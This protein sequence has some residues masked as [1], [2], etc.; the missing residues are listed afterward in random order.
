MSSSARPE[1]RSR[2]RRLF[3]AMVVLAILG[4]ALWMRIAFVRSVDIPNLGD[5]L[6]YQARGLHFASHGDFRGS[7]Y[8]APGY[9]AFVGLHYFFFGFRDG[10]I[11]LTQAL[12]ST[13]LVLVLYLAA[14]RAFGRGA[15]LAAALLATFFP[16]FAGYAGVLF[17]EVLYLTLVAGTVW[18]A[19]EA[20]A[21][22]G[23][24]TGIRSRPLATESGAPAWVWAAGAGLLLGLATLTR[25][26]ALPLVLLFPAWFLL[27]LPG[28]PGAT[29]DR[30]AES[31]PWR[32]RVAAFPW[33]LRLGLSLAT[34]AA[35]LLVLVPWTAR[36]YV[37][38]HRVVPV[39][40]VSGLNLLIGNNPRANGTFTYIDY[41]DAYQRAVW[42]PNEAARDAVMMRE[43]LGYIRSHPGR[44]WE[45]TRL[46][47][48]YFWAQDQD[49]VESLYH[50]NRIPL[51]GTRGRVSA[52]QTAELALGLSGLALAW[53]HRHALLFAGGALYVAVAQSVFYEAP[54]YRLAAVPFL[55]LLGAYALSPRPRWWAL[56][57]LPLAALFAWWLISTRAALGL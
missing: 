33:R 30:A 51:V 9:V 49:Y 22:V 48:R 53:R 46:R 54:R 25:S 50:W 56:A 6:D 35:F 32:S 14:R 5:P 23:S 43:A 38:F 10:P 17:A 52:I 39:D 27:P 45:L 2:R 11:Y 16:P 40:T 26:I 21:R 28:S 19:V 31:F 47:W 12:L 55:I 7:S 44:F 4:V 13:L 15:A 41:L 37:L 3:E 1:A 20:D 42:I 24:G 18:L 8:R 29:P 36:N 34:V 57:S